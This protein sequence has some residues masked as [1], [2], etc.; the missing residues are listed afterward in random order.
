MKNEICFQRE[1]SDEQ[2]IRYIFADVYAYVIDCFTFAI[3]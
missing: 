1:V 2:F 3:F